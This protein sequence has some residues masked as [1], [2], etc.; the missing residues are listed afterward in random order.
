MAYTI[1]FD[2]SF[3]GLLNSAPK[4]L[5]MISYLD[6]LRRKP[7]L[8][9]KLVV[10]E[11]EEGEGFCKQEVPIDMASASVEPDLNVLGLQWLLEPFIFSCL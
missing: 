4:I 8:L 7:K 11:S 5:F 3:T 10:E 2:L 9:F 1:K 6:P